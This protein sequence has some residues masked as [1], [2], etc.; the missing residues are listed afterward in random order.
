MTNGPP[1]EQAGRQDHVFPGSMIRFGCPALAVSA[2]QLAAGVGAEEIPLRMPSRTTSR[3]RWRRRVVEG[4][5][6]RTTW[7]EG[8]FGD[9]T[10]SGK[11]AAQMIDQEGGF[12]IERTAARGMNETASRPAASGASKITGTSAVLTLRAPDGPPRARR[13]VH[14]PARGVEFIGPPT[15]G[16]PV[17]RCISSCSPAM[18]EQAM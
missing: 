10:N 6:P 17:V 8:P 13:R 7:D 4:A 14:R 11:C 15:G 3:S 1:H 16:V 12:A 9:G 2:G 18:T 5:L